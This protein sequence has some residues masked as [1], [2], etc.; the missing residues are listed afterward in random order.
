MEKALDQIEDVEERVKAYAN[1]AMDALG[2]WR[3]NVW[4]DL[5]FASGEQ[6]DMNVRKARKNRPISTFNIIKPIVDRIVNPLRMSSI[7]GAVSFPVPKIRSTTNAFLRSVSI[8]SKASEA[9]ERALETAA[10]SGYGYVKVAIEEKR[11]KL[12][13]C[14]KPVENPTRV[15]FD[16]NSEAIDGSDAKYCLLLSWISRDS[17]LK[18]VKNPDAVGDTEIPEVASS[19]IPTNCVSDIELYEQLDS[20]TCRVSRVVGG[21]VVG[22]PVIYECPQLL[23]IPTYGDRVWMDDPAQKFKGV[24]HKLRDNQ[25]KINFEQANVM[26]LIAKAPKSPIVVAKEAMEGFKQFYATAN[27]ENHAYMPY[28]GFGPSGQPLPMPQRMDNN[29]Q[30]QGLQGLVE[31]DLNMSQRLSGMS[32]QT[33]FGQS[34]ANQSGVAVNALISTNEL[35]TSQYVQNLTKTI[36]AV[37]RVILHLSASVY[38]YPLFLCVSDENGSETIEPVVMTQIL[39]P[40]VLD[41]M[42]VEVASGPAFESRRK[43]NIAAM[44]AAFQYV[45]PEKAGNLADTLFDELDTPASKKA[46]KRLRAMLPPEL[47]DKK[48]GENEPDPEAMK[49]LQEAESTINSLQ[50]NVQYMEGI[51]ASLQSQLDAN[52][53]KAAAD[54]YKAELQAQTDLHKAAMEIQGRLDLELVKAGKEGAAQAIAHGQATLTQATEAVDEVEEPQAVESLEGESPEHE[55]GETENETP[56]TGE[57]ETPEIEGEM[58]EMAGEAPRLPLSVIESG[59]NAETMGESTI[60]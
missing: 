4:D 57:T 15:L 25:I 49:A 60:L 42:D 46:A 35:S 51:I 16:P 18:I 48:E 43:E 54:V 3:Q 24:V 8:S 38:D 14:V 23:V 17:A 55:A 5:R 30:T 37:T 33:L 27:T 52:E 9:Y 6:W 53:A 22:K 45:G 10:I 13:V 32:D 28:N 59:Q 2:D 58:P 12:R 34:G 56:E 1:E 7:D 20:N 26:E 19:I 11:G 31:Q 41:L 29:A 36:E 39:T 47:L 44:Q 21:Q 40:E 50:T